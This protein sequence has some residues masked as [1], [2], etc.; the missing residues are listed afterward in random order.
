MSFR[1]ITSIIG[2]TMD[3]ASAKLGLAS[4][5]KLLHGNSMPIL[6]LG[7]YMMNA[8]ECKK[9]VKKALDLGIRHIDTAKFYDNEVEI[10]EAIRESKIPRKDIFVT[11]KLWVDQHGYDEALKACNNSL[12]RLGMDY[13]D[14]YLIHWPG[15]DGVDRNSKDNGKIRAETW[16]ALEK[17][18]KDGKCKSIGV[19]NYTVKHLEELLK[20]CEYEPSVN[21]VEF[22][23]MLYQ[24][25]L[26]EF[27][28]KHEIVL[29]GYSPFAKGKLIK[30]EEILG[31]A[32]KYN[33]TAA[34]VLIRWS[35]QHNVV[36]IPKSGVE[37][38]VQENINVFDFEISEEDMKTLDAMNKNWHC[39]WN[40]ETVL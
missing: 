20:N 9:I 13:L 21:Q 30:N 40:P 33:K 16:R 19:S 12:K 3:Q 32:K 35:L 7:T 31:I 6:G 11:S 10:G 4:C 1:Q 26:L 39:T 15:V 27:C 23:P 25:D 37:D 36:C 38:R 2:K 17:L 29:E 24:K 14:L 5:V 28:R 34:Q 22:H 18:H 8:G